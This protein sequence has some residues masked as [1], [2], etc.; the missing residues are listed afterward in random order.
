MNAE[1]NQLNDDTIFTCI[2]SHAKPTITL[3]ALKTHAIEMMEENEMRISLGRLWRSL[4]IFRAP[5]GNTV[6]YWTEKTARAVVSSGLK[7]DL[8]QGA[9]PPEWVFIH[10]PKEP[11]KEEPKKEEFATPNV[12]IPVSQLVSKD[13]VPSNKEEQKARA[14]ALSFGRL[15]PVSETAALPMR[16]LAMGRPGRI[17]RNSVTSRVASVM[18]MYRD[19]RLC[20]DA[21]VS[22]TPGVSR[23]DC[24]RVLTQ[25]GTDKE[26]KN[27]FIRHAGATKFDT[28][29]QWN[30]DYSYPFVARYPQDG[31]EV[32]KRNVDEFAK[33]E[34]ALDHIPPEQLTEEETDSEIARLLSQQT[35]QPAVEEE[36]NEEV[37]HHGE[38][39]AGTAGDSVSEEAVTG[40]D[41]SDDEREILER[42]Q[43]SLKFRE[44]PDVQPIGISVVASGGEPIK[45]PE[46]VEKN[47]FGFPIT[48]EEP[49]S[50]EVIIDGKVVGMRG[51][52]GQSGCGHV[53]TVKDKEEA[54]NMPE[55]NRRKGDRRAQSRYYLT[56]TDEGFDAV[57]HANGSMTIYTDNA[58]V[59]LTKE[60]ADLIQNLVGPQYLARRA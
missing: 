50:M 17:R 30:C 18:F 28:T 59:S 49:K 55:F 51:E 35:A 26:Y 6:V 16:Q 38:A 48:K 21:V 3:A 24:Y 58:E 7:P 4:R 2:Q 46:P 10:E 60:Q 19:V 40:C 31:E 56:A 37:E 20:L 54:T 1:E 12:D 36:S 9:E 34:Q 32:P 44:T 11:V 53:G 47:G 15:I 39:D 22:L 23:E 29:Y 41:L 8:P 27:Y 5:V 43:S 13:F 52:V 42:E 57:L 33:D 45:E 14:K 25:L